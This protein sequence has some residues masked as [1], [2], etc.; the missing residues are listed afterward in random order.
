V[1]GLWFYLLFVLVPLAIISLVGFIIYKV[2]RSLKRRRAHRRF[3]EIPFQ[4]LQRAAPSPL[5]NSPASI[6]FFGAETEAWFEALLRRTSMPPEGR[7]KENLAFLS[8]SYERLMEVMHTQMLTR[9][10]ESWWQESGRK[11]GLG[12]GQVPVGFRDGWDWLAKMARL[13]TQVC[14]GRLI[15]WDA[16]VFHCETTL[17]SRDF[18]HSDWVYTSMPTPAALAAEIVR[19]GGSATP[20]D[21]RKP[22]VPQPEVV[23]TGEKSP[24]E[25]GAEAPDARVC[26]SCGESYSGGASRLFTRCRKCGAALPPN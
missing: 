11:T 14:R 17:T 23:L 9:G 7:S 4:E 21:V 19:V 12:A 16:N 2:A 15:P 10:P 1:S 18:A 26:F 3:M 5:E 6:A 8:E 13:Q 24:E 22:Q 20:E 25:A